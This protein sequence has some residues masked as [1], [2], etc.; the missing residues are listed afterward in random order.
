MSINEKE[1]RFEDERLENVIKLLKKELEEK[2]H[3]K[4]RFVKGNIEE[5][6]KAWEE[7]GGV[8]VLNGA[9][10][11]AQFMSYVDEF[12]RLKRKHEFSN[13]QVMK[14][15]RMIRNPYFGRID[16]LEEG[17]EGL[18]KIYIGISGLMDEDNNFLVYDWRAPVSSMYYD[19][20]I[21]KAEYICPSCLIKGE[22]RLKRQYKI[23]NEKIQYMFDSNLK[24]D[25][26][27]LQQI[28]SKSADNKMKTIITTIQKEQNKVIRNEDNKILIVQGPAGSGKTSIALHRIA[29]LLYKHRDKITSKNILIFSP[30][31]IFN[32]Y[33]SNVLPELGEDNMYQVTYK[34]YMHKALDINLLK[35]DMCDMMEDILNRKRSSNFEKRLKSIR[36]KVSLEFIEVLKS[37]TQYLEKKAPDFMDIVYR[38]KVL[39]DKNEL[40]QLF[41]YDYKMFPLRK[42]LNKIR[43]RILYLLKPLE[44][45]RINEIS[46]ELRSTGEYFDKM[47][48]MEKSIN[49]VREETKVLKQN[50]FNFTEFNLLKIYK[51]LFTDTEFFTDLSFK[52]PESF[53]EIGE[54]TKKSIAQGIL[55]YEDQPALLYLKIILGDI[56]DTSKIK[57]IIIDEAQ[58]YTPLQYE[59]LKQLFRGASI[60]MLGDL[61]QSINFYM[62][63]GGYEN[64]I[65]IFNE[66]TA[67][68][69][70]LTKSY[71]STAEITAF[72]RQILDKKVEGEWVLRDGPKPAIFNIKGDKLYK[73]VLDDIKDFRDKGYKSIAVIGRNKEDSFK[74]YEN[75]KKLTEIRLIQKDDE[76]YT[77]GIVA[78]PSYLSKGLEFDAVIVLAEHE[79]DY[80]RDDEKNLLY[81]ICTRALHELH[82][83]ANENIKYFKVSN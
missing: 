22:M 56:Q 54:Y 27:I 65:N 74:A 57:Y 40:L 6:K 25:D 44:K 31:E 55:N 30:N 20:E 19:Y 49:F 59:I 72:A 37:Y 28:L 58:D 62:N 50:I 78:I 51:E 69:I 53:K 63:T 17:E 70:N 29:Y 10:N 26:E 23:L 68:V 11:I 67:E 21:G 7:V 61:N 16:F 36:Y 32:D 34:D 45:E 24:I 42:R 71:R 52:L 79:N 14:L 38:N 66:S 73:K 64:V 12:K 33:I 39:V 4:D 18:E 75:L 15:E 8:S 47:E 43:E 41:Y 80:V 9:D 82:I 3:F 60:T 76:E 81:T 35:E 5:Q 2:Q 13:S 83:Y 46:E 48:I 77:N 1:V